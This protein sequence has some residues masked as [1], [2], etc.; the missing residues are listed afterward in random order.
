M[1]DNFNVVTSGGTVVTIGAKSVTSVLYPYHIITDSAGV[2]TTVDVTG[3]RVSCYGNGSAAGDTAIP[4]GDTAAHGIYTV[5]TDHTRACTIKASATLAATTDTGLVVRPLA[6][7]DGTHST[8]IGD[9]AARTIYVTTN[10]GTNAVTVKAASTVSVATDTALVVSVRA[11]DPVTTTADAAVTAGTAPSKAL[12]TAVQFLAWGSLPACTTAQTVM[13][14]GD[15]AGTQKVGLAPLGVP[16]Y[17]GSGSVSA[18]A[19]TATLTIPSA[20]MGFLDGFD[21]DGLGATSG[22]AVALTITGALGGTLTYAFGV[23]AGATVPV[24]ASYRFNPPL[25]ASATNTNI[26]VSVASFGTGNT[27]ASMTAY[28]HYV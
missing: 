6:A 24:R 23:P 9:A 16:I 1:A 14:Q 20:K 25:Q 11:G 15:A 5:L 17:A 4:S 28:G 8:P 3:L 27:A 19:A 7:S 13:I 21:I 12:G 18:A 22:A 26:V 2:A 10:D